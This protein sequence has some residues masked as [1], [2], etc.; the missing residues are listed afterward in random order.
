MYSHEIERGVASLGEEI[1]CGKCGMKL[2]IGREPE[3]AAH[4]FPSPAEIYFQSRL[5]IGGHLV[6]HASS[7][8]YARMVGDEMMDEGIRDGDLLIIDRS[9][10]VVSG[11]IVIVRVE[12]SMLI[13]KLD[14]GEDGSKLISSSQ[15]PIEITPDLDYEIWGR[16]IHS[17]RRH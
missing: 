7:T 12:Q 2:S 6:R 11:N 8:F 3:R 1:L 14:L 16:V 13:R 10:P 5:D 15:E 4:G 17:I 9:E